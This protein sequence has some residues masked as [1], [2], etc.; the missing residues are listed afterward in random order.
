ME[1]NAAYIRQSLVDKHSSSPERQRETMNA[2][3]AT[4]SWIINEFYVDV[5]GKRSETDD[6]KHRPNFQR[7]MK[8]PEPRN[9]RGSW[10]LAK[11]ASERLTFTHSMA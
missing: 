10:Y 8:T 2:F 3:A 11:N 7:M 5:G 4:R 9:L 6:L 1:R